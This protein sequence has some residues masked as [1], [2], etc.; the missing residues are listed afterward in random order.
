MASDRREHR[1]G[2]D[3]Q[4]ADVPAAAIAVGDAGARV[5]QR[6]DTVGGAAGDKETFPA[7]SGNG[8]LRVEFGGTGQ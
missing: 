3:P 2:A 1:A 5:V 7:R 6:A 8:A 4:I